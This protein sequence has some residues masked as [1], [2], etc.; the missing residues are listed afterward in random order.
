[1]TPVKPEMR[2]NGAGE[3]TKKAKNFVFSYFLVFA[4]NPPQADHKMQSN[5]IQDSIGFLLVFRG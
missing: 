5:N 3:N 2:F 4:I 1:M